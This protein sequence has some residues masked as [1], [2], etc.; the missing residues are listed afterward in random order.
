M[1]DPLDASHIRE[2]ICIRVDNLET[3]KMKIWKNK[4]FAFKVLEGIVKD[5]GGVDTEEVEAEG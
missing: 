4:T 3:G 2:G 1:A 5:A